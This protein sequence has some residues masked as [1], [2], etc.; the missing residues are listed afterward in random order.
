M[1]LPVDQ[2]RPSMTGGASQNSFTVKLVDPFSEDNGAITGYAVIVAKQTGLSLS[3][4]PP[5]WAAARRNN[6]EYYQATDQCPLNNLNTCSGETRRR[7]R[8]TGEEID[9]TV[10]DDSC[11]ENN[12]DVYCNG[13][14]EENTD[15]YVAL[16]AYTSKGDYTDGP[17]SAPIRTGKWSSVVHTH[18]PLSQTHSGIQVRN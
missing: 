16:R 9:F 15:Y 7:K 5:R 4:S 18:S 1:V 11:D 2:A 14:L 3:N 8:A 10:G 6:F 17:F 12:L 13:P